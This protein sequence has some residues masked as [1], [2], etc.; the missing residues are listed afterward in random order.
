MG[1]AL[2]LLSKYWKYIVLVLIVCA[3][4]FYHHHLTSTIASQKITIVEQQAQITALSGA[5]K[6]Q[7]DAIE[8]MKNDAAAAEAAGKKAIEKAKAQAQVYKR[9]AD[10]LRKIKPAFPEDLCRSANELINQELSK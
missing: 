9:R 10:D 4:W 8:Q 2:T 7:N 3:V 6:K 5:L 1:I